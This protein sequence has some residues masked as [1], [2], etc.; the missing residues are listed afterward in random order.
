MHVGYVYTHEHDFNPNR[1][2]IENNRQLLS[3]QMCNILYC[4]KCGKEVTIS[5]S[6]LEAKGKKFE[7]L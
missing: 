1:K 2:P 3:C 6:N 7:C 4:E 5:S